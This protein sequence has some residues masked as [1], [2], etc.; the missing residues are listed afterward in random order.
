MATRVITNANEPVEVADLDTIF[1]AAWEFL[2][3]T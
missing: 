1:D 2:F 3:T